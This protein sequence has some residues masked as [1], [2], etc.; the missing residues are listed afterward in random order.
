[1]SKQAL[2]LIAENKKT[3][4]KTL[5]LGNCGLTAVPEEIGELVWLEELI[6]SGRWSEWNGEKWE[7]RTSQNKGSENQVVSL[8]LALSKIEKLKVLIFN[9]NPIADLSRLSGLSALQILDCDFTKVSD[10]SP[11]S[12]LSALQI[13]YCHSTQVSDLSPLSGLSALQRLYCHSTQVSDLS[14]LSGLS[15]LQI[16]YCYS[17]QVSDLSPLSGLSA[18]QILFCYSTQVSDLSPLSGLSALQ[19]LSC[20]STQ[21]SD[22]SP[23]SGLSALQKLFCSSTQVSDLS[24]LSGL[25]ALQILDCSSTQVSDLSPLLP[26]VKK[27][28]AVEW[29]NFL[30]YDQKNTENWREIFVIWVKDCPFE[31]A[32]VARIKQGNEAVL[33]YYTEL[34]FRFDEKE[35]Q[36]VKIEEDTEG[37]YEARMLIIGEPKAG[38]TSLRYKLQDVAKALPTAST[39]GIDVDLDIEGNSF[40]YTSP[41]GIQTIFRYNVWDFG[42]Q[43]QYHPT[44][45]LFF[46]KSTLYLLVTNTDWNKNEE[47]VE[48]WLETVKKLGEGSPVLRLQNAPSNRPD[49]TD[50]SDIN[51]RYG[52]LIKG[53]FTLNLNRVNPRDK[54]RYSPSDAKEFAALRDAIVSQLKNLEHVGSKVPAS[55]KRIREAL[56]VEA[57]QEPYIS[58]DR[59]QQICNQE[60]YSDLQRQRWLSDTFHR[61]GIFLHY[62][63]ND[64][65]KQYIILQ[66]EWAID[67]VFAVL[68]NELVKQNKGHFT[69]KDLPNIWTKPQYQ[70][71]ETHLL[72]LLREFE[73]CYPLPMDQGYVV[74]QRLPKTPPAQ[75]QWDEK[76]NARVDIIFDFLPRAAITRLI[77]KMHREIAKDKQWVWQN[78]V[79]FDGKNLH[80]AGTQ[81]YVQEKYKEKKIAIRLQGNYSEDMFREIRSKLD[82]IREDFPNLVVDY[83]IYCNCEDCRER[84]TPTAFKYFDELLYYRRELR[85]STIECRTK[86]RQ[87]DIEGVMRGIISTKAQEMD[88]RSRELDGLI[89]Q[90]SDQ[91]THFARENPKKHAPYTSE[92][93]MEKSPLSSTPVQPT[94]TEKMKKYSLPLLLTIFGFLILFFLFAPKGSKFDII[95][96]VRGE[97]GEK[98]D[99]TTQKNKVNTCDITG[100]IEVNDIIPPAG[101]VSYLRLE[102]APHIKSELHSGGAYLFSNVPK[103]SKSMIVIE[104]VLEGNPKPISALVPFTEPDDKNLSTLPKLLFDGE[105]DTQKNRYKS[106]TYKTYVN[107]QQNQTNQ[108]GENNSSIQNPTIKNQ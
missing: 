103:Y 108:N 60:Q 91:A 87:V 71:M 45:Q 50:W 72:N 53:A 39:E 80:C 28:A 56:A 82:D 13:L 49:E 85:S 83:L 100:I 99:E 32:L 75:F 47:D 59:F 14:P 76:G 7:T 17:T 2:A 22:L 55:W 58:W 74:P 23:L 40:K 94:S 42:G 86:K 67:A 15:A 62:Q 84:D 35:Q 73:L 18:L 104:L 10:L 12:G 61:L 97:Q 77:V 5:D 102:H 95:G 37:L 30:E 105:Y 11:L 36:Y 16:L 52:Q 19:L 33:A 38:K 43:R 6:L 70:G 41:E 68:D 92:E 107:I 20:D 29:Q 31:P 25:S 34:G 51:K 106:M 26:I 96:M 89:G 65:L 66:N 98:Q 81:A 4:A 69:R 90:L 88:N 46:A 101:S 93:T 21:V 3:K 9:N 78:G 8:P 57:R 54:E 44:H 27:G 79:V 64:N 24:P 63:K 1:M 48:F